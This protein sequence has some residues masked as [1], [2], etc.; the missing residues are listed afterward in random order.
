MN[1]FFLFHLNFLLYAE[2]FR[3]FPST[4]F[5]SNFRPQKFVNDDRNYIILKFQQPVSFLSN[6]GLI[7]I[8]TGFGFGVVLLKS[9]IFETQVDEGCNTMYRLFKP[10]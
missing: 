5:R 3:L 1:V 6:A 9:M 7:G 2:P 4:K 10:S 8:S